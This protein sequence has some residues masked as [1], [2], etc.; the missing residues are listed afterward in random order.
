MLKDILNLKEKTRFKN[1]PKLRIDRNMKGA[2]GRV[3]CGA[4]MGRSWKDLVGYSAEDL[5]EYLE[6]KFTKGMTWE[7]QGKDGW[8]IDHIIPKFYFQYTEA[9]SKAFKICWSLENLQPL[10]ATTEIAMKYG[11]SKDYIGNTIFSQM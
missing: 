3:L 8:H 4:K 2:I 5:M 10:W 1:N 9:E 6:S 7:N 11:E